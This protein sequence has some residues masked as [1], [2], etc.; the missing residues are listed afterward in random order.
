M[1]GLVVEE[2]HRWRMRGECAVAIGVRRLEW[3]V[4]VEIYTRHGDML[5]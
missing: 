3:I 1:L 5:C 2:R 4:V